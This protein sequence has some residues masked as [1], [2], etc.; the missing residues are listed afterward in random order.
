VYLG[1]Q[2]SPWFCSLALSLPILFLVVCV[3]E[4]FVLEAWPLPCIPTFIYALD[5]PLLCSI[6]EVA[7]LKEAG[8]EHL[9]DLPEFLGTSESSERAE[10][11]ESC[12]RFFLTAGSVLYIPFGMVPLVTSASKSESLVLISHVFDDSAKEAT[13]AVKDEVAYTLRTLLL[14]TKGQKPWDNM[15][16]RLN[17]W[18]KQWSPEV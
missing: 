2:H 17:E 8:L 11:L 4:W 6:V 5:E 3:F 14:N 16:K 7:K 9:C 1:F 15:E 10:I 12:P 13:E 18:I